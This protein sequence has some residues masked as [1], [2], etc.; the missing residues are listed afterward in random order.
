MN[1]DHANDIL[2]ILK[3]HFGEDSLRI[4]LNAGG[5]LHLT[6][7]KEK[8]SIKQLFEILSDIERDQENFKFSVSDSTLTS[9]FVKFI[10]AQEK[11]DLLMKK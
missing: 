11:M 8:T 7:P 10:E 3:N 9:T 1:C 4:E 6:I 5:V 2:L